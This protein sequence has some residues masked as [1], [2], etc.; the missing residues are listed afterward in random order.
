MDHTEKTHVPVKRR[1][2]KLR[3]FESINVQRGRWG[4]KERVGV[5]WGVAFK[6][7]GRRRLQKFSSPLENTTV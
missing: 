4:K 7:G 6:G 5:E 3:G 1:R 2:K